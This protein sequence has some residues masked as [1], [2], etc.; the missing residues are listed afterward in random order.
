MGGNFTYPAEYCCINTDTPWIFYCKKCKKA[1]GKLYVS[2]KENNR[3]CPDCVP[4][5]IKM[6]SVNIN[7]NQERI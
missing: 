5:F 7:E 6:I 2:N 4:P 3:Y 1:H